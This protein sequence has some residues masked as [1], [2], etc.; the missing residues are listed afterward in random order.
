MANLRAFGFQ[1][2]AVA[3]AVLID[4]LIPALAAGLVAAAHELHPGAA[5]AEAVRRGKQ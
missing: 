5:R 2:A 1:A 3:A 4:R